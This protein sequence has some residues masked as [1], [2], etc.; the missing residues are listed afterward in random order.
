MSARNLPFLDTAALAAGRTRP[1]P[2]VRGSARGI[3]SGG[4]STGASALVRA[5]R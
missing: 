1:V 3:A 4:G 2:L 5:L